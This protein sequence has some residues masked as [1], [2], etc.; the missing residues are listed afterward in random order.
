MSLYPSAP[1]CLPR[2]S[3]PLSSISDVSLWMILKTELTIALP[4]H[5]VYPCSED[6][7]EPG[8]LIYFCFIM[9]IILVISRS[10]LCLSL[11]FVSGI[12]I[13]VRNIALRQMKKREKRNHV[14]K[15]NR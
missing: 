10:L 3:F 11:F 6:L 7:V 2:H 5:L 1:I 4:V 13:T 14:Q 15:K 9:C 8:F 12:V